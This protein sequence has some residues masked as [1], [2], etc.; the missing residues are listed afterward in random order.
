MYF[1]FWRS[2]ANNQWYWHIK[3]GN[4]EIVCSSEGYTEKSGVLNAIRLVKNSADSA[5]VYDAQANLVSV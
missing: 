2:D 4:N 1:Q 5:K 3:G